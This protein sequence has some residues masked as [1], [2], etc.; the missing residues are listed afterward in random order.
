MEENG[1][2]KREME[3]NGE[4]GSE[5]MMELLGVSRETS[6]SSFDSFHLL[7]LPLFDTSFLP[8]PESC[9]FRSY[10]SPRKREEKRVCI[11]EEGER[12]GER[13]V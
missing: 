7:C 1:E 12:Q 5:K 9:S 3:E 2:R 13:C 11:I 10:F 8:A 6:A 4:G